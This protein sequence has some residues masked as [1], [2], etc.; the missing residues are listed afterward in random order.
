MMY[1]IIYV[2]NFE[3]SRNIKL[4]IVSY[5]VL[6]VLNKLYKIST[7]CILLQFLSDIS[8]FHPAPYTLGL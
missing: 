2:Y 4:K 8:L 3:F 6:E 1:Q 5:S 7:S